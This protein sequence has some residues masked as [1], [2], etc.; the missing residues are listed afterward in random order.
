MGLRSQVIDTLFR[1]NRDPLSNIIHNVKDDATSPDAQ[2]KATMGTF[3]CMV[4]SGTAAD[5]DDIYINTDGD[6]AWTKIFDASS[7]HH[8]YL[9]TVDP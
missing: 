6:T 5:D 2:V 7:R 8:L 3:F 9:P 1:G 4:D